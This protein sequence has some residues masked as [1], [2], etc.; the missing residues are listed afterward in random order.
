MELKDRLYN[1][2]QIKASHNSYVDVL[3]ALPTQLLFD[4]NDPAKDGCLGLELDIWRHSSKYVPYSSIQ[5][6]Y[7]TVSHSNGRQIKLKYF[8]DILK[9]WHEANKLHY[10][11]FVTIDIKSKFGGYA[12]FHEEIDTYLQQYFGDDK[13]FMP[14]AMMPDRKAGLYDNARVYGWHKIGDMLGKFIFCLSGNKGWKKRYSNTDI[15]DRRCFSD[16]D[17]DDE[18]DINNIVVYN[19]S[20][21]KGL[22]YS[23][24]GPS[25]RITRV[26]D[27]DKEKDWND[28]LRFNHSVIATNKVNDTKWAKVNNTSPINVKTG[29]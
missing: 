5:E 18:K 7:F 13:I 23:Y 4:P 1:Q 22:K 11:V 3:P 6:G 19:M 20:K 15:L 29:V 27:V 9:T 10:P 14:N 17:I 16:I 28:I 25:T 2:I 21:S 8:L 12:R 26:Y 24:S